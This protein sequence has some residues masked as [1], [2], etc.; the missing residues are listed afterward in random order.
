MWAA[1]HYLHESKIQPNPSMYSA[2]LESLVEQGNVETALN[3]LF[4]MKNQD[5]LPELSAVQN[6]ILLTANCG[7]SRLALELSAFYEKTALRRL[8]DA[9]WMTCLA[10]AAQNHYVCP[11]KLPLFFHL[12]HVFVKLDGVLTSW[13]HVTKTLNLVPDEGICLSVLY[14]AA[15]HG[16]PDLATD[17]LHTLKSTD[18]AW[19]EHHFAALIEALCRKGQLQD[20]FV[21]LHVMRTNGIAPVETTA[22]PIVDSIKNDTDTLDAAWAIIDEIHS[23]GS[24]LDIDALNA[25]VEASIKLGDLQRAIGIYKAFPDYGVNPAI[26]TYNHLLDGCITAQ[27]RQLGDIL[28]EDMKQAGLKPDS[29]TYEKMINLCLTQEYYEDAFYYLEEMKG[30]QFLPPQGVYE[31]IYK[32]CHTAL[33]SRKGMV[34]EEMKECGYEVDDL[35]NTKESRP[36]TRSPP[37]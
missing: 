20:A 36:R 22:S 19:E 30:A 10:T 18:V 24:G 37:K 6:V 28:L 16:A 15:R 25:V 26:I 5:M 23:N 33:D 9:V 27:H 12:I 3:Y 1:L 7:Y 8:D 4:M 34:V 29:M 11:L 35:T 13:A 17:V 14:T 2:I 21:T 32:K 31:A